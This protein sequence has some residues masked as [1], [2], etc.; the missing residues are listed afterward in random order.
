MLVVI[1]KK[2]K[3]KKKAFSFLKMFKRTKYI[4][5]RYKIQFRN[6]KLIKNK[7]LK[8]HLIT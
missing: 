6:N 8:S 7:L 2:K 3:K 5:N 1:Y 4:L